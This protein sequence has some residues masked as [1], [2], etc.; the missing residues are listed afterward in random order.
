[1]DSTHRTTGT[2]YFRQRR[3]IDI[4]VITDTLQ[5]SLGMHFDF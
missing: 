4:I 5:P 2:I 3:I 1:M